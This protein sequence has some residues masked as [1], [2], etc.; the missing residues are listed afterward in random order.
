[1]RC[2]GTEYKFGLEEGEDDNGPELVRGRGEEVEP[3][4]CA[5]WVFRIGLDAACVG[6]PI[7]LC[8]V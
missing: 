7:L 5:W 8:W 4:T 6:T 1:M 2:E 3:A